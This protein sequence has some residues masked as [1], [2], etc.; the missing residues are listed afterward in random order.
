M[1]VEVGIAKIITDLVS[2]IGSA[3]ISSSST[4]TSFSDTSITDDIATVALTSITGSNTSLT[5]QGVI[6]SG[7]GNGSTIRKVGVS[8]VDDVLFSIDNHPDIQK[9]SSQEVRYFFKTTIKRG[10]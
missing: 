6:N 10:S 1:I 3:T 8:T 7:A 9:T 2:L 4:D 5:A